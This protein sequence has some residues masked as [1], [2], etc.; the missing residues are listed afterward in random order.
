MIGLKTPEVERFWQEARLKHKIVRNVYHARTFSDPVLSTKIDEITELCRQG[1]KRG[2]AHL[3]LDF[4]TNEI[5]RRGPGDYLV[6]LDRHN[7]PVRLA[8]MIKVE[9]TPYRDVSE[10]F[11]R[12]EGEGDLSLAYWR[13]AHEGYFKR[14]LAAWG[15]EW[16]DDLPVVC[17]SFDLL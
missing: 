3:A 2:T 11:A 15:R 13:Q 12:R 10:E 16:R 6:V 14:Q 8:R 4:E 17:E 7:A 5:P 9:V 1:K